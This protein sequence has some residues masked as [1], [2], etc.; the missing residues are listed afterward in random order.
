MPI[1]LE[2][3]ARGFGKSWAMFFQPLPI[4]LR[5]YGQRF[6]LLSCLFPFGK[7][8]EMACSLNRKAVMRKRRLNIEAQCAKAGEQEEYIRMM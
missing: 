2:N 8:V 3:V 7:S 4:V 5:A 6:F 1:I